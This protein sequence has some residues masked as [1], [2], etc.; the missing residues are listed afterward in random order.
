MHYPLTDA[1]DPLEP[2]VA[3]PGFDELSRILMVKLEPMQKRVQAA[4][5]R[6]QLVPRKPVGCSYGLH[7]SSNWQLWGIVACFW[8]SR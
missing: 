2:S 7:S 3:V 8:L 5:E 1:F 4:C 6:G